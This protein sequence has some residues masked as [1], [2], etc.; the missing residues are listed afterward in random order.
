[1]H[2]HVTSCIW[3]NGGQLVK[4]RMAREG[5]KGRGEG[6][7]RVWENKPKWRK[8]TFWLVVDIASNTRTIFCIIL[9]LVL[10]PF[11]VK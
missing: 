5:G 9:K 2:K 8:V 10:E 11:T 6:W 7:G 1:M 4:R 3:V